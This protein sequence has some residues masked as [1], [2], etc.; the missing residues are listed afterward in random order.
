MH[1]VPASLYRH[2]FASL[3]SNIARASPSSLQLLTTINTMKNVKTSM[4]LTGLFFLYCISSKVLKSGLF[5][6]MC[7]IVED[8]QNS[9]AD[10]AG[11][12][13]ERSLIKVPEAYMTTVSSANRVCVMHKSASFAKYDVIFK[14][15]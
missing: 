4:Y 1:I 9:F 2:I 8:L 10:F 14:W 11:P 6:E 15:S 5:P 3:S 13:I 7:S 12:R